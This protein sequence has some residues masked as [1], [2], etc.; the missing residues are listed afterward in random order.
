MSNIRVE[1]IRV[2]IES[3]GKYNVA[4]VAY[5]GPDGKVEGKKLM[6]FAN[7]EV[8]D[9]FKD[10]QAGDQ[11]EVTSEKVNGF[12]NWTA[13]GALGKNTGAPTT[14]LATRSTTAPRSNFETPEERAARQ[15]YI[16]KQ[17]SISSAIALLKDAKKTPSVGEVIE[18]AQ[19]FVDFV[20]EDNQLK[21]NN[22]GS[23]MDEPYII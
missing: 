17:S 10:A 20:F 21:L 9:I 22:P 15:V 16:V 14:A 1:V 5:K 7:K 12:W 2:D 3:K 4:N 13:V 6:S 19:E 23:G 11:F 18:T 8:Y